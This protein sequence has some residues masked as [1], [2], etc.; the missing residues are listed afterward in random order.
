M[1]SLLEADELLGDFP[2][3][4]STVENYPSVTREKR[5]ETDEPRN[6]GKRDLARL[7]ASVDRAR[8]RHSHSPPSKLSTVLA[9]TSG[10]SMR[11]RYALLQIIHAAQPVSRVEL[12]RRLG[13]KRSRVSEIINPLLAAGVCCETSFEQVS[14]RLGRPPVGLTLCAERAC[15]IGVSIGVSQTHL[16]VVNADGDALSEERLDTPSD[17]MAAIAAIHSAIER[18]RA[19]A[20]FHTLSAIGVT[21][22]GPTDAGRTRLLNAPHLGWRNIAIADLLR[23]HDTQRLS[24]SIP[25]IV[26]TDATAAAVYEGR[27]R[28]HVRNGGVGSDFVVVRVGTGIGVGL[29]LGGEVY[30]SSGV[31]EG[32][33]C[34]FGHMTIAAGGKLCACGNRGCWERYASAPSVGAFYAGR[35]QQVR[36]ARQPPFSEIVLRAEGG[37][38]RAHRA[39]QRVG[40]YLGIGISNVILALGVPDIVV[41][42]PILDGWRFI[43][44]PLREAMAKSLPGRLARW[45]VEAGE[46]AGGGIGGAVAVAVAHYLLALASQMRVAA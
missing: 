17:P 37:D 35:R 27:R 45:S 36:D 33:A 25:I 13:I 42:G 38:V 9:E 14:G 46:P 6:G 29:V 11:T 32:H 3:A 8:E 28:L 5:Y 15:F 34:D 2:S 16:R 30:R 20:R 12:A 1:S 24:D 4:I 44:E 7:S 19:V 31:G 40:A 23:L 43:R 21:V 22:P 41:T 39:L 26:E 18:L 10:T